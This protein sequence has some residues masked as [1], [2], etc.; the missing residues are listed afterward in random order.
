MHDMPGSPPFYVSP[1]ALDGSEIRLSP[2]AVGS[3]EVI[4]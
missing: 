1:D 2:V 4:P 3:W